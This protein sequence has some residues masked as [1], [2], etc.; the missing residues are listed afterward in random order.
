MSWLGRLGLKLIYEE[1]KSLRRLIMATQQELK[2]RL[3]NL[4]ATLDQEQEQIKA[5]LQKMTDTIEQ[6]KNQEVPQE[7]IDQ[8]E[9]IRRDLAST[10]PDETGGT[11]GGEGGEPV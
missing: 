7:I 5:S 11:E 2:D 10:V 4:Q 9:D 3:D 6:M 8:V 1:V